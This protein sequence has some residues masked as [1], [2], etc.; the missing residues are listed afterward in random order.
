MIHIAEQSIVVAKQASLSENLQA[1]VKPDIP[2]ID[3][4]VF[5][6]CTVMDKARLETAIKNAQVKPLRFFQSLLKIARGIP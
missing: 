5:A 6:E 2:F 3:I 1:P 4:P